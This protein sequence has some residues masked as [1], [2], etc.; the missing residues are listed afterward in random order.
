VLLFSGAAELE[1]E[2]DCSSLRIATPK[3]PLR[4]E[5]R[6]PDTSSISRLYDSQSDALKKNTGTSVVGH[7]DSN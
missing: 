7:L 1:F 6:R 3:R 4:H 5:A 2:P